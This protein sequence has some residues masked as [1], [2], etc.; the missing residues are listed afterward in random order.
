MRGRAGR[1]LAGGLRA[2]AVV[3]AALLLPGC[4]LFEEER[5]LL[6][7]AVVLLFVTCTLN[8][9]LIAMLLLYFLPFT[10]PLRK[11]RRR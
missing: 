1:G 5:T 10:R 3:A 7:V 2:A 6:E 11:K 8:L 9:A 4:V